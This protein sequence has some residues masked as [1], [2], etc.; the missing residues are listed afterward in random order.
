MLYK[1]IGQIPVSYDPSDTE[2]LY[3][4]S[5]LGVDA[6]GA[7]NAYSPSGSGLVALDVLSDAGIPGEGWGVA[8]DADGNFAIQGL[9]GPCPGYFVS[10]TSLIDPTKIETDPRRYVDAVK[11]PFF[12]LPGNPALGARIGQV[13]MLF[14]P[15]TGD[16]SA[17]I[18]A[19]V[20]PY[21]QLGEGSVNL[22]SN[23]GGTESQQSALYGGLNNIVCVMFKD[24]SHEW[25]RSNAAVLKE[26]N[27][28]FIKWGGFKRLKAVLPDVDWSKF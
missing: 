4:V 19:D 11:V 13:G 2:T 18:F 6:D 15:D 21:N 7:P 27:D 1:T 26:S 23:L 10:T 5:D 20:G 28:L 12:V 3:W 17:A 22:V 24:S 8:R 14:R 25:P 9:S 16:S